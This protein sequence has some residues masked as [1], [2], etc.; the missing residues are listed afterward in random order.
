MSWPMII[1]DNANTGELLRK[2]MTNITN[3]IMT[4]RKVF[5]MSSFF[6]VSRKKNRTE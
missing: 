2:P 4:N 6:C 5:F 3:V 1:L